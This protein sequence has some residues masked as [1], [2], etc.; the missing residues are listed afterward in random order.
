[1][2]TFDQ[3]REAIEEAMSPKEIKMAIGIASDKRYAKGNMTGA[4]KAIEKMKKGLSKHPQ[5]MAVL[6]RQNEDV[7]EAMSPKEKA[8]HD[9]AIADFKKKGGKI[10]KLKPGYA[11]GYHGKSDPGAGI[12]G[13]IS[14]D[15]TSQFGTKKKVGSMK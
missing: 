2:K 14:K 12:K 11:A 13:M 1:M 8:A 15:D 4:V 5:V 3:I 6:K 9:K 10:K 7:E